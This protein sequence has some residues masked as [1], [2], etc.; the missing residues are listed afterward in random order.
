MVSQTSYTKGAVQFAHDR[1]IKLMVL[2]DIIKM[3]ESTS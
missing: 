3:H 2:D 1:G